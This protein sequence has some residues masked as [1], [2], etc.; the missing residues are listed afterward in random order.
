LVGAPNGRDLPDADYALIWLDLTSDSSATVEVLDRIDKVGKAD[1]IHLNN[2]T[3]AS[4]G[5][6]LILTVYWIFAY[7]FVPALL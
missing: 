4:S 7:C 1:D 3:S 5:P 2:S 6:Y